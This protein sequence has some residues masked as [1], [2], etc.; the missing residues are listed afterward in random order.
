MGRTTMIS[1]RTRSFVVRQEP[2][3][4]T[5]TERLATRVKLSREQL[6]RT[7]L[8]KAERLLDDETADGKKKRDAF[9]TLFG[10]SLSKF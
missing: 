6:V 4:A 3:D 10:L 5:K 8:E 2:A 9:Y 7:L 1:R